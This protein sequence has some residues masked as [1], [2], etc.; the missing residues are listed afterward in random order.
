MGPKLSIVVPVYNGEHYLRKCLDSILSQTLEDFE[1]I[2]VNDGS[3]DKTLE[4]MQ[5]FSQR[6]CRVRVISQDNKGLGATRNVG[7]SYATGE[8]IGFVDGDDF[9]APDMYE[10]LYAKA[11]EE[12]ADI[13]ITNVDLYYTRSGITKPFRDNLWYQKMDDMGS[14]SAVEYPR[15]MQYI[16]VWDR[17][18][19][20]DFIE[21]Y[22]L[23]NPENR[24]YEDVLFTVQANVFAKRISVVNLPLY[25]YRKE[26]GISIVD[27]EITNDSY[28]FD[29][30][31]NLRESK[32]F[33]QEQNKYAVLAL[34]FLLWQL[35]GIMYHQYNTQSHD[36][37]I[38]FM[39][40]LSTILDSQDIDMLY[41]HTDAKDVHLYLN[42]LQK[43]KYETTYFL[44]K[45][46]K[47]YKRDTFYF[48]F[49]FPKMRSYLKIKKPGYRWRVRNDHENAFLYEFRELNKTLEKLL[50]EKHDELS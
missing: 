38:R 49:R 22:H 20:R 35:I 16:G 2:C 32:S 36:T 42:L 46:R 50:A 40:E 6:D 41:E 29:F 1:L 25:N 11:K 15:V 17:I 33:L 47:L 45:C 8:Y 10:L 31:K 4:I 28:K 18:Y 12:D 37:F 30:L 43:K 7:I 21:E 26:T 44:Y 24:I 14:F 9:I 19:R 34:E 23:R 5:S 48:I 27:K 13:V 3:S 39:R